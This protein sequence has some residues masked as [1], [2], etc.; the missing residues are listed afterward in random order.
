MDVGAPQIGQKLVILDLKLL[1]FLVFNVIHADVDKGNI[2]VDAA[3]DGTMAGSE[4][5][6][7]SFMDSFRGW[8]MARQTFTLS[9]S[10]NQQ[11]YIYLSA[12]TCFDLPRL[13]TLVNCESWSGY[14]LP[15]SLAHTP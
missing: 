12:P 7:W 11:I 5:L 10:I 6:L 14:V 4:F 15:T 1:D 8:S 2:S 9:D 13:T 3:N